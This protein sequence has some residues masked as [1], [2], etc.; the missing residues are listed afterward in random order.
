MA[1][2]SP[3]I[4]SDPLFPQQWHLHNT[5]TTPGSIPGHDINV[6]SVWPDYS[7][8]GRLIG[9]MDDGI[10]LT[11]P[12]LIAN[13]R[14]ELAWDTTLDVPG[15]GARRP[16][17]NHGTAVSGLIAAAANNGI[18]GVGVAWGAEFTMYRMSVDPEDA[19]DGISNFLITTRKMLEAGVEIANNSWGDEE[20][21][22]MPGE[23]Q[24]VFHGAARQLAGYGRDNLGT[25]ILFAA[26]NERQIGQDTNAGVTT[27]MPWVI[28]VAASNQAGGIAGYSTPGASILI[29]APGSYAPY[30]IV[31][32]DRQGTEGY[33]QLPGTAGDYTDT[34][35]SH[36][37]G[38]S[39]ATPIAS[40]VVALML[41]ANRG[42]GYRDVQEIL[43][44]SARRATFLDRDYDKAYN[45]SRDWNG[46][47]LLVS[48]D[49]GYG[50]IDAHAAVRL[51]ESW[52]KV[53]TMSNLVAEQ[54]H[55]DRSE[56]TAEAGAQATAFA[57]F[58][59]DYRVEQMSITFSMETDALEAVTLELVSPNGTVS[60]LINNPQPIF[61]P[62]HGGFVPLPTRFD[63]TVTTV[64]NWGENLGGSWV[65]KLGNGSAHA[66]VRMTDLSI[67]AY[68]AGD[69]GRNGTQIFTDEFA[70][71]VDEDATRSTIDPANGA[72][73]N[74]A[75]VTG[76][77]RFD[78]ESGVSWIGGTTVTLA[79][80]GGFRHLV[81]GDGHDIL[82]GN[83]QNNIL[84]AGRGNNHVDGEAGLDV[85]RLIGDYAN[86]TVERHGDVVTVQSNTLW[87]GGIDAVYNVELLQFADRVVLTHTPGKVGPDLFD[88]ISYMMQ[89]PDVAN[90]Y[91][92]G[93]IADLHE[94]YTTYG[95]HEGRNP[96][97]LFDER[98]YLEHNAD[99]AETVANGGLVNGFEHYL[100]WGW[101]EGRAPSAWMD[102]TAYLRDNP[103]VAAA[104]MN[105]LQ[106]YLMWGLEEGRVIT[107]VSPDMWV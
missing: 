61:D 104:Q 2:S 18:G 45:G 66:T 90:F 81:S 76:D 75:A 46:G 91:I 24:V 59:A 97:S 74:A 37:S 47:A 9:V 103:D 80:S 107:A 33:N 36:F 3:F 84:M 25:V 7:G 78:L 89:N 101:R 12:D 41:E 105:P 43:A 38:T 51:A 68:T 16:D 106:H 100:N 52:M 63:Y 83:G 93:R 39:A 71:F 30:S 4:P 54:G 6:L 10:D 5:G 32:T 95:V 73:L 94:H 70:R 82:I 87:G 92:T 64:L 49:F 1:N 53:G 19:Q 44:Y 27:S 85:L 14:P 17:D 29:T 57:S 56:L 31:T 86:Y 65:V 77:V 26:G 35:K 22:G 69:A 72:I 99:V 40:G 96:N 102:V 62:N 88:E 48:H 23:N 79:D 98:W 8:K 50:H 28:T 21:F 55:L 11:H 58:P 15:G 60:R 42:L 20:P 67:T 34:P 13:Y